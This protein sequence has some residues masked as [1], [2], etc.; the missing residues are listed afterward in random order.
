MVKKKIT[1][2]KITKKKLT[3]KSNSY[4]KPNPK[5]TKVKKSPHKMKKNSKKF[6]A[7]VIS[8]G[9]NFKGQLEYPSKIIVNGI[10][11]G[12]ITAKD[13]EINENC[14]IQGKINCENV[15]IRG[16]CQA[17]IYVKKSCLLTST[18]VLNCDI[19]YDNG[20]SIENGAKILGKLIPKNPPLAL[21]NYTKKN[22]KSLNLN[23]ENIN[24]NNLER[25]IQPNQELK[26]KK[27]SSLD[28]IISNIFK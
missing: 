15:T 27:I 3:K 24:I 13:I 8:R 14:S 23:N 6:D 18:S 11:E 20:I 19:Y 26:D 12:E 17:D 22:Y 16:K 21:P 25:P 10:F 9:S 7:L 28:K 4:K 5:K 2:K 1:K